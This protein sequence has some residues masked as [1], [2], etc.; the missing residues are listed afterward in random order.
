MPS[1]A[2]LTCGWN[3]ITWDGG[4]CRCGGAAFGPGGG[5]PGCERASLEWGSGALNSAA[6]VGSWGVAVRNCDAGGLS[7]E[8]ALRKWEGGPRRWGIS[9]ELAQRMMGIARGAKWLARLAPDRCGG[10]SPATCEILARRPDNG[11][12][13]DAPATFLLF[14]RS[15]G[16]KKAAA[17]WGKRRLLIWN[18]FGRVMRRA[19]RARRL[20]WWSG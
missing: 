2:P 12:E 16:Q 6:G 18:G 4:A 5:G 15:T 1:G 9:A 20:S 19:R 13:R 17:S 10:V 7:C 11:L 14:G 8:S 3:V